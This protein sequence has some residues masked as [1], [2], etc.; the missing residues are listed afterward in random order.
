[1]AEIRKYDPAKGNAIVEALRS[2]MGDPVRPVVPGQP[3]PSRKPVEAAP[4][5][6]WVNLTVTTSTRSEPDEDD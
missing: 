3:A 2:A 4:S 5:T 6:S 1:M